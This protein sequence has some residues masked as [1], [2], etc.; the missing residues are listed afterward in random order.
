MDM[1]VKLIIDNGMRNAQKYNRWNPVPKELE[2]KVIEF[3]LAGNST[4]AADKKF[5][6]T[7]IK[8]L[9]RNGINIRSKKSYDI[10]NNNKANDIISL[11]LNG[12]AVSEIAGILNIGSKAINNCLHRHNIKKRT[13]KDYC[14]KSFGKENE[15]IAMYKS[16]CSASDTGKIFEVCESTVLYVLR[17]NRVIVR[18]AGIHDIT[19]SHLWKGGVSKD[20][21]YMKRKKNSYRNARKK[22]DPLYKLSMTLRS[23]ISSFFRRGKLGKAGKIR[24]HKS[25]VEMLGADFDTVF[26]HIELQF[27]DGMSWDKYGQKGF[28]IDHIIPLCSAKNEED[29]IRLMHYTNLRPLWAMDN[30]RKGGKLCYLTEK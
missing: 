5:G 26:K 6:V 4:C 29:L 28:H 22:N 20:K 30:H 19:K 14:P 1:G 3:Y 15:I 18:P 23:R 11:Y 13:S 24:K 10:R 16:G 25:T 21:E 27:T 9:R 12:K 7:T 2:K 17:K 8:I